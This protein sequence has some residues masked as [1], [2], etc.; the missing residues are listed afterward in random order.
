MSADTAHTRF[1]REGRGGKATG[2]RIVRPTS[3][4]L[5]P[6]AHKPRATPPPEAAAD[7]T[8][9]P[10]QSARGIA[11]TAKDVAMSNGHRGN[12][13]AQT[14]GQRLIGRRPALRRRGPTRGGS[15]GIPGPVTDTLLDVPP[16]SQ[17]PHP[18][19]ATRR[20]HGP[21]PGLSLRRHTV[22]GGRGFLRSHML[23]PLMQ[24]QARLQASSFKDYNGSP[25]AGQR[26]GRGGV[27]PGQSPAVAVP[28]TTQSWS[29][30]RHP[31]SSASMA[32]MQ[33]SRSGVI[34]PLLS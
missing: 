25:M 17:A 5:E 30:M 20:R 28:R 32:W 9:T 8:A 31:S 11:P 1:P 26:R 6:A 33:P 29:T 18:H 23:G 3:P 13:Q 27:P 10:G 16:P 4:P 14:P 21:D 19:G 34:V 12:R 7:G 22:D 24:A 2:R 15:N